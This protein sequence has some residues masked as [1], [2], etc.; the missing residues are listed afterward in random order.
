MGSNPIPRKPFFWGVLMKTKVGYAYVF[1]NIVVYDPPIEL[2]KRKKS[3]LGEFL[4]IVKAL[5]PYDQ[6]Y[7]LYE[8]LKQDPKYVQRQEIRKHLK[9]LGIKKREIRKVAK[10][11]RWLK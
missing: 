7:V 8:W 5:I 6:Y 1:E 4:G 2:G 9:R 10:L 11:T 3:Q